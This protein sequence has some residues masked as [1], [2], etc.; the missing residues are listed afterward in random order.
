MIDK[1]NELTQFSKYAGKLFLQK[2]AGDITGRREAENNAEAGVGNDRNMY[3]YAPQSGCPHPKQCQVLMVLRDDN[4]EESAQKLLDE[5]DLIKLAEE[6][7]FLLLFP[8]PMDEGWNYTNDSE[9]ENDMD[10]LVRCFGVLKGSELGVSGFNGM[11]FYVAT[12]PV[13]SAMMMTMAALK[14]LNVPAMMIS[15]FPEGYLIPEDALNIEV[16]AWSSNPVATEYIMKANGKGKKGLDEDGV[17][18]YYGTNPNV[19]LLVTERK[20]DADSLKIAWE[21]LFSE[22]RR[23][24]NDTYGTY[25]YRTN[26]TERGFVGHVKDDCLGI[27]NGC[28]HTWYEYIPP[29]LRGT[30]EKVPLVFYFHGGGCVPLYGAEQSCWHDIADEENFIVIYPEASQMNMWNAWNDTRLKYSDEEFFLALIEHMNEVHPIDMTRVYVSGFSMGGMMSN[31]MACALPE[32]VAAAAPCNAYNEGY[33]SNYPAMIRRRDSGTAMKMTE[34]TADDMAEISP[35]KIEADEKKAAYD[36]RMPVFQISGLFD[37]EWPITDPEDKRVET[38]NY[39]KKY[40]NIPVAPFEVDETNES[41]L[42]AD[43]TYYD[44]DDERFLHH[45]WYSSDEGNESL[46][47][48]FLAKRMPHALDIRA[49]R[50]AWEFIKRF[51]RNPDGSLSVMDK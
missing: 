43:E 7:N 5:L 36:Y 16:A 44:G 13:T 34:K 51:S 38:F 17:A 3:C 42:K 48:L 18:T 47:E 20:T 22:S 45:K 24:Q 8:N 40:N 30:D 19:R 37:Q 39:W 2:V 4:K 46:Y 21:R 1:L 12:T 11:T 31:A 29:Q 49:P 23:W 41:G 32:T 26:F 10:Y 9:K 25:Q 28:K 14:P 6:K 35:V 15:D 27:N 33:F 50:Y